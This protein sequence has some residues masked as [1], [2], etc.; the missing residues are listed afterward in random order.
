MLARKV[1]KDFA[2]KDSASWDY[3]GKLLSACQK[4]DI[5]APDTLLNV[6]FHLRASL[7]VVVFIVDHCT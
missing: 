7:R 6:R 2:S 5:I 3:V 1:L 4:S